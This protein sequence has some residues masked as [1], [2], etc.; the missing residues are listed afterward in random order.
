MKNSEKIPCWVGVPPPSLNPDRDPQVYLVKGIRSDYTP[1]TAT[2]HATGGK[3]PAA[4]QTFAADVAK[5]SNRL[6]GVLEVADDGS[7]E[8]VYDSP[9]SK[10]RSTVPVDREVVWC[11]PSP[12]AGNSGP[13][14]PPEGMAG[15]VDGSASV[16]RL[17]EKPGMFPGSW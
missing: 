2:Y 5:S 17:G 4:L 10:R 15:L 8:F 16:R 9:Q 1:H 3:G 13:S 11:P 7:G 14:K 12:D 6:P